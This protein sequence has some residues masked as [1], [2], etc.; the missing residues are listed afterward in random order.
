MMQSAMSSS[1]SLSDVESLRQVLEEKEALLFRAAQYGKDLLDQ[2][3]ELTQDIESL[4]QKYSKQIEV[5]G[6]F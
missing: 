2:N 4:N 6:L 5:S 3:S 1:S